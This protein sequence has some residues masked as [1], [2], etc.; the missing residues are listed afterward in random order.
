MKILHIITRLILG[1]AQQNTVL[2]CAAQV[3][4]GHDVHLAF[5]PIYGPEGSLL[6]EARKSGAT[7]H[8]VASLRRAVLPGHDLFCYAALRRLIRGIKPDVVHTHSSKAGILGRAAAWRERRPNLPAV[9]HTVHGL[10]FHDQ[11]PG[12][13]NHAYIVAERFAARRCHKII[14]VT[15]AMC[16][17]F[18]AH[19]IGRPEQ[20][21]VIPSGMDVDAFAVPPDTR[22]TTR[23]ELGIP[24]DAPV[25]GIVARLDRLKGQDDLLDILPDLLERHHDLRLLIVGGGWHRAALEKRVAATPGLE[26]RV[27]FTG[28]VEPARIPSLL[29]A[30]DV[31]A[32]PSYQEGQPRTMVQA[33]LAGVAVVGYDAG[34]IGE[35]C[36][37]DETGLLVPAGD[38]ATLSAAVDR[39]LCDVPLR[40]RLANQGRAFA[41]GRF[42]SRNMVAAIERVYEQALSEIHGHGG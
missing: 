20:F 12:V 25:L 14:G 11:Q 39:L 9:I 42:D 15:Q 21:G 36:R 5:G 29:S 4:A 33:L 8:E 17:A 35:V 40:N 34:G 18:A 7:L 6:N 41:R 27:I 28:L 38:R 22:P 19:D 32:L 37:D 16:E 1:G 2:S 30:M 26:K 13:I 10:P 31:H 23:K 3:R 24:L